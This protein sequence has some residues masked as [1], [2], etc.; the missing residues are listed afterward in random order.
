VQDWFSA[1]D[2]KTGLTISSDVAVFDWND[3]TTDPADY[4]ILQPLLLASRKSCHGEGNYY[5]Q[6]GN[7]EYTFSLYSHSGDW[8]NSFREGTQSNQPLKAV[9]VKPVA[10]ASMPETMSFVSSA[11]RNVILST[12]KK[13]DDDGSVIVRGYDIE[14][15][16]TLAKLNFAVPF[17]RAELTNM[18]EEDGSLIPGS[19]TSLDLKVG[20]NSIETVKLHLK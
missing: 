5:L 17:S 1:S 18:I 20:H 3:P 12:V 15:M 11:N 4:V 13:C 16:D 2:G 7:H 10:E 19:G 8:H 6:A 9:P 14:G